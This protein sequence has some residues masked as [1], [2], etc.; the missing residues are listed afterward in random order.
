MA[1]GKVYRDRNL[2]IVFLVTLMAVMGVSAITPAFPGVVSELGIDRSEIGLLITV[3][4]L[5]GV[6]L[7][8]I[9]EIVADRLGRKRVLAPSLLVF[10]LFGGACMFARDIDTLL[11]LRFLQG[12]GAGALGSMNVTLIGDLFKGGDCVAAMGYNS[13]ILSV[14]TA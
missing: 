3:F 10:G 13:A 2:N 11:F 5:P 4:T 8:L 1:V 6:V 12:I 9:L 7:T 14:G